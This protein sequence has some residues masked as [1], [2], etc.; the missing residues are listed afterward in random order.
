M[1]DLLNEFS[2]LFKNK[3]QTVIIDHVKQ[4]DLDEQYPLLLTGDQCK[5][6]I[7]VGNYEEFLRITSLNGFPKI[8][9]K[10]KQT[11]YPRDAVREWFNNNWKDI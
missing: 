1:D 9:R 8:E 11:R 3:I 4:L 10:G 2:D 6:M 7:G 5:K